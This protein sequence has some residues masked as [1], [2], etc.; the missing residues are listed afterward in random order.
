MKTIVELFNEKKECVLE[1]V[2]EDDDIGKAIAYIKE[3]GE[4]FYDGCRLYYKVRCDDSEDCIIGGYDG[5]QW[6]DLAVVDE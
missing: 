5:S 4:L 2:F 1:K 6:Y 3:K